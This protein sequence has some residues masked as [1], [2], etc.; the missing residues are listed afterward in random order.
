MTTVTVSFH[1]VELEVTGAFT[2][3]TPARIYAPAEDCYPAED[4]EADIEMICIGGVD[5][6]WLLQSVLN[7]SDARY[8]A[9]TAWEKA[10]EQEND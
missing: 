7:D 1:D 3:A 6:T 9:D 10:M 8:I 4:G 2:P 5:V